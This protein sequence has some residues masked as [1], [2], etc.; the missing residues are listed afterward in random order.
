MRSWK[1]ARTPEETVY[2]YFRAH[3]DIYFSPDHVSSQVGIGKAAGRRIILSLERLGKLARIDTVS[4]PKW[5][6]PRGLYRS[7]RSTDD[8][9]SQFELG[10]FTGA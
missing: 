5:G 8:A 1:K 3:P 2:L 9:L 10:V 4:A 6:R 7:I